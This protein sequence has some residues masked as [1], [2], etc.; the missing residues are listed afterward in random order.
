MKSRTTYKVTHP[1]VAGRISNFLPFFPFSYVQVAV[2][3]HKVLRSLGDRTR[4]PIDLHSQPPQPVGHLHLSL[5]K[6][7]DL[8]KFLA[9]DYI[10]ELAARSVQNRV[11]GLED[12]V[13]MLYTASS[14]EIT[15]STNEGPHVNYTMQLH[16]ADPTFEVAIREDGA[17]L[18]RSE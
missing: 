13:F 3:S 7:G 8:C 4:M 18:I 12:E 14:D 10:Q 15:E 9:E 1:A 5:V 6:D 11:H 16:P 2:I 17:T